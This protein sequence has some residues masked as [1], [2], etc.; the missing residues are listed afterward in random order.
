MKATK[1]IASI[2]LAV[3]LL[4]LTVGCDNNDESETVSIKYNATARINSI[5]YR[6]KSNKI[7]LNL[8]ISVNSEGGYYVANVN[9]EILSAKDACIGGLD[10]YPYTYSDEGYF[11]NYIMYE[12][13]KLYNQL[14]NIFMA[15]KEINVSVEET[16]KYVCNIYRDDPETGFYMTNR[17]VTFFMK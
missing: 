11:F 13:A 1:I 8:K 6:E 15:E 10:T 17:K 7:I 9:N 14:I 12:D 2:L 3:S 16:Y 4:L 5:E